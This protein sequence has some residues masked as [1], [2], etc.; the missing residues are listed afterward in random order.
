MSRT[1][2]RC[3]P[4]HEVLRAT[5]D[6]LVFQVSTAPY[7]VLDTDFRI[8]GVNPAY[9]HATGR[10]REELLGAYM[11]DAIPDAPPGFRRDRRTQPHRLPGTG[12][13]P[14]NT[15]RHGNPALRHSR[16]PF[17]R[18][19]PTPGRASPTRAASPPT[20]AP[21][22]ANHPATPCPADDTLSAIG[23]SPQSLHWKAPT[24]E[25]WPLVAVDLMAD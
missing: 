11:F 23:A 10:D 14:R 20:T 9:Q 16:H 21:P 15:G 4:M 5:S 8:C 19:L 13:A 12:P 7:A 6:S 25:L 18:T 22:T 2:A 17:R 3:V 24:W 1:L